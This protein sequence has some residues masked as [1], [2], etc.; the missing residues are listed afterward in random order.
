MLPHPNDCWDLKTIMFLCVII[1][2]A[3]PGSCLHAASLFTQ[4]D[5]ASWR[6]WDRSP[7][8]GPPS[9]A[10]GTLRRVLN[11]FTVNRWLSDKT[12]TM[13][14]RRT[15]RSHKSTRHC[16]TIFVNDDIF[17]KNDKIAKYLIQAMPAE[18][19]IQL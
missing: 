4:S 5:N 11:T 18:G 15:S 9:G 16:S 13:A 8:D 3:L 17:P 10:I 7:P 6:W 1:M 2:D 14:V 12:D 19:C